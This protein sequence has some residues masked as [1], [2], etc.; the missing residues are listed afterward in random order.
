MKTKL[1]LSIDKELVQYARHEAQSNGN[2]VSGIFS[3]FILSRKVQSKRQAVPKVNAM[4]GSL[5][6]YKIDDSKAG[7]RNSYATKYS[8]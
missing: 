7:I 2:S 4:L 6:S 1:T 3:E 5:K 8:N